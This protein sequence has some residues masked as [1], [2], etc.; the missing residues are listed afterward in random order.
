MSKEKQI[1]EMAEMLDII[2][3]ARETYANDVTDHTENEY[4]REGLLNAGYRKQNKW[5]SIDEKLPENE[6][7]VL[8]YIDSKRY[9]KTLDTDRYL[10]DSDSW[11]RWNNHITHWM[12]LPEPPKMKGGAE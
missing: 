8:V 9:G 6:E 11:A 2:A 7:R 4:I 5:I 12:P 1:E 3:E 10:R